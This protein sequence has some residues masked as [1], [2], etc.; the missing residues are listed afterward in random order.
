MTT[1]FDLSALRLAAEGAIAHLRTAPAPP[2]HAE[3]AAVMR[4]AA[5]RYDVLG[6]AFQIAREARDDYEEAR[7]R[8]DGKH[9][10]VVFR[11][12]FVTKYLFWERRDALLELE[13]LVRAT[14]EYE[15][16]PDHEASVLEHY[17]VAADRA[18]ERADRLAA[19]TARRDAARTPL[20]A[21]DEA[22]GLGSA[23]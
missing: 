17:R 3:A 8:D 14:W 4:L 16:R 19:L 7:A 2:L 5:M 18:I 11:N 12:L 15:N 13:P 6:R 22:I 1:S 20:P 9:D 10:G 21:F 23:P